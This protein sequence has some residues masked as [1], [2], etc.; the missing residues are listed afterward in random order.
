MTDINVVAESEVV[1]ESVLEGADSI[2]VVVDSLQVIEVVE[3]GPQGVRGP[4]ADSSTSVG[5]YA[6][7]TT[8]TLENL[9]AHNG[10]MFSCISENSTGVSPSDEGQTAWEPLNNISLEQLLALEEGLAALLS[11]RPTTI[12]FLGERFEELVEHNKDRYVT[13]SFITRDGKEMNVAITH[14]DR[15]S[16]I[17]GSVIL[18][19]GFLTIN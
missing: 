10:R 9:V 8:Y 1:I 16:L 18:L 13:P 7:T 15:N 12:E 5:Y 14:I 19:D 4:T 17:V 11:V 2:E 6:E 3:Q